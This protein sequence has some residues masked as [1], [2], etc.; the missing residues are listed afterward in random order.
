MRDSKW[1]RLLAH[2]TGSV[3]QDG[4][5]QVN[6][7]VP[8]LLAGSGNAPIVISANGQTANTAQISR[9][10]VATAQWLY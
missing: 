9:D 10:T 2:V 7:T 3:K 4:L 5:D 6:M 8:N 1:V